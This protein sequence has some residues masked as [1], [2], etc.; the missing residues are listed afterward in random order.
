MAGMSIGVGGAGTWQALGPFGGAIAALAVSPANPSTLYVAA[1][2]VG[3][4]KSTD[5]GTSWTKTDLTTEGQ[6]DALAVDPGNGQRVY[7]GS[8]SGFYVSEDGGL[9]WTRRNDGLR[10]SYVTS[11]ALDPLHPGTV[12]VGGWG[13]V[14]KTVS[15]GK[16]WQDA[17]TGLGADAYV[18]A[19][20]LDP[21]HPNTLYAAT[22]ASGVWRS[23]DGGAT[24]TSASKG[25]PELNL[26]DLA[27]DPR[28]PKTL[29]AATDSQGI[30]RSDDGATT[31][32]RA[33]S[34][35]D[36]QTFRMVVDP[37]APDT[38]LA[39]TQGGAILR[40][41]DRGITWQV[42]GDGLPA[43]ETPYALAIRPDDGTAFAGLFAAGVYRRRPSDAGWSPANAGLTGY[44]VSSLVIDAATRVL[45]AGVS[46]YGPSVLR[47]DDNGATWRIA[48]RGLFYP[49]VYAL[50]QDPTDSRVLLS[51]NGGSLFKSLDG[52]E[53]WLP[54]DTGLNRGAISVYALLFD[55]KDARVMFCA[56]TQGVWRSGD[57]GET[58]GTQ[59][60][61]G[62]AVRSLAWETSPT[63]RLLAGTEGNGVYASTDGGKTWPSLGTGLPQGATV[64]AVLATQDALFAACKEAGLYRSVDDGKT[65]QPA[66]AGSPSSP[67]Y[68][69]LAL[70]GQG[71]SPLVGIEAGV[72]G[73]DRA[74]GKW[75]AVA[76]ALP[77]G[78]RIYALAY[79]AATGR[80]YAGGL[81]GVFATEIEK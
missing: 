73:F 28:E 9:T 45:R 67:A 65:W 56:T 46:T 52:G 77:S 74:S 15:A 16:T 55:P 70:P 71:L 64:S 63:P 6:V 39:A 57:G 18:S 37:R 27:I 29:Y 42:W 14:M 34:D 76:T 61:A 79:D 49:P 69:L 10:V 23:G 35:P 81:G 72:L 3:V 58:W 25:L 50:V 43:Y 12:Y 36:G 66:G 13:G 5:G 26:R 1:S 8:T 17:S 38:V 44:V 30:W 41:A 32:V 51:G 4:F 20:A 80:L 11:L 53:Q 78:T 60:L 22:G 2:S 54:S 40:S 62:T 31:W 59:G 19:L 33:W 68:S 47:S 75:V 21:V 24:W 48:R 7:A